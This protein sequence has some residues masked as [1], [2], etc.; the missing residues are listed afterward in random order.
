[1]LGLGNNMGSVWMKKY[2]KCRKKIEGRDVRERIMSQ[3]KKSLNEHCIDFIM[4]S[5]TLNNIGSQWKFKLT[6]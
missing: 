6:K 5:F 1:M 2:Y 3:M 4:W